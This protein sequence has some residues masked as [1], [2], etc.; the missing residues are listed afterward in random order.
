MVEIKVQETPVNAIATGKKLHI[1]LCQT[2]YDH[3]ERIHCLMP[4]FETVIHKFAT[5]EQLYR[6]NQRSYI[7]MV[8]LIA[9]GANSWMIEMVRKM[10]KNSSTHFI[11]IMIFYPNADKS[12]IIELLREG[13]DEV[14]TTHW[15]DDLMAAKAE[16]LVNRSHRDLSVNPSTKLPGSS[17]IEQEVDLRIKSCIP[18]AVCYGDIDNF[19]AYNDYHGYV[20]GDKMIRITSHII[21]NVVQDLDPDGFVGHI[22]GDD[23]VFIIPPEK[24]K[25]IC[26]NILSTFD[27]IAPY[28]YNEEDRE[29]GFIVTA[30]R[31]GE[32]EKFPIFTLSIAVLINQK[33]MFKH[34]GE[35]SH[36]MADLK[37]YTKTL[38]G[39]NYMI[40]RRDRY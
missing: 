31:K 12:I 13:A 27:R 26:E 1:G 2:G 24:V 22:G 14:T 39:S 3:T 21:R 34:P 32:I 36:M 16:M 4:Q 28:R 19:K 40:E 37:K 9:Q 23:F 18:F 17:A 11:P 15:D 33:R 20:Y 8:I 5:A 7:D 29:K 6:Q 30:N 35:M 10:K 25:S 38:P